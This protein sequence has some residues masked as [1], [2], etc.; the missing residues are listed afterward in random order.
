VSK[1]ENVVPILALH[2]CNEPYSAGTGAGGLH[3]EFCVP[4][5]NHRAY[6]VMELELG[7][8]F[9]SKRLKV[10]IGAGVRV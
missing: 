7:S 1:Q 8:I 9:K 10:E 3:A 4:N 5:E 2:L 6:S